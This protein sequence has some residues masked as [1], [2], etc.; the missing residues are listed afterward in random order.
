MI[1]WIILGIEPTT[2]I[3]E[4]KKSYA[5]QVKKYHP[6]DHPEE[7]KRL[8]TAYKRALDYAKNNK[9]EQKNLYVDEDFFEKPFPFD[10]DT[11]DTLWEEQKEDVTQTKDLLTDEPK[12]NQPEENQPEKKDQEFKIPQYYYKT[13]EEKGRIVITESEHYLPAMMEYMTEFLN[14]PL[15]KDDLGSW[16]LLFEFDLFQNT[17][18]QEDTWYM[19][20]VKMTDIQYLKA[21]VCSLIHYYFEKQSFSK[22]FTEYF[23]ELLPD[24]PDGK[25]IF[26]K[27]LE[28]SKE[29]TDFYYELALDCCRKACKKADEGIFYESEKFTYLKDN[30]TDDILATKP[31]QK[32]KKAYRIWRIIK[33][34]WA[35]I[36]AFSI[37]A[38]Y[39]S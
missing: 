17:I 5:F 21:S 9:T 27:W 10:E 30:E 31:R 25:Y 36:F 24:T 38:K 33:I 28:T 4:I 1:D 12:E 19:L 14:Q 3:K 39:I 22:N 11:S 29:E 37:L 26:E 8:Q 2:D 6:E 34:I 16:S 15:A 23:M 18:K 7:F 35:I 13:T 32:K 20:C